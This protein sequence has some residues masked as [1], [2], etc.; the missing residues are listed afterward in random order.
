MS[1][2]GHVCRSDVGTT[3]ECSSLTVVVSELDQFVEFLSSKR[4]KSVSS[5]LKRQVSFPS[6]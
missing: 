2:N 5:C 3:N 6:Q 1:A 4:E